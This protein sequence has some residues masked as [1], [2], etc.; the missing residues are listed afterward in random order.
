M[1]SPICTVNGNTTGNGVNVAANSAVTIAI[2]DTAGVKSWSLRCI[3]TDEN[4]IAATISDGI[5]IDQIT[6]TATLT[7]PN[8]TT[9]AALIFE[10]EVNGGL[11]VNGRKDPSLTTRFGVFVLTSPGSLR[12]GAFDETT[13]GDASFGWTSKFNAAVRAAGSGGVS[14]TLSGTLPITV[15]NS[16]PAAPV[17]SINAATTSNAGSMSSTD[18]QALDNATANPTATHIAKRGASGECAFTQVDCPALYSQSGY[19]QIS[20]DGTGVIVLDGN[21]DG[22]LHCTMPVNAASFKLQTATENVSRALPMNWN[23]GEFGGAPTWVPL[24]GGDA[25]AT[26]AVPEAE[27]T[28]DCNFLHGMKIKSLTLRHKGAGTGA[29]PLP[30]EPPVFTLY[31]KVVSTGVATAIAS[32]S[33]VLD[34]TFRGNWRDITLDLTATPHTVDT[35]DA[36]YYILVTSEHD[37]DAIP[38]DMIRGVTGIFD[39]PAGFVVGLG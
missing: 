9:G 30:I 6:K 4:H 14:P 26:Q 10:S 35:T 28:F 21:T 11:D 32:Q 13:E 2:A 3:S 39:F 34:G 8:A 20:A 31:R 33:A 38:G 5:S 25:Y 15:N 18:K 37:V 1:T 19:I 16:N 7:S 29:N 12:V 24:P 23:C 36:R 27:L 17:V 22:E